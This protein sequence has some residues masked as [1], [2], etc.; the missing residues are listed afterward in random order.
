MLLMN[1]FKFNYKIP[2]TT[3]ISVYE[4]HT[5]I[6]YLTKIQMQIKRAIL[7]KLAQQ[8]SISCSQDCVSACVRACVR[9]CA[10]CCCFFWDRTSWTAGWPHTWSPNLLVS[11]PR[12]LSI[13]AWTTMPG[14]IDTYFYLLLLLLCM[15][16][17]SGPCIREV[18][19]QLCGTGSVL[20]PLCECRSL[21]LH[22][23]FTCSTISLALLHT[24]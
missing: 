17:L 10:C 2:V 3:V 18:R 9:V 7:R 14:P 5:N 12:V 24:L 16:L 11:T 21:G 20:P 19:G 8:H 4:R 1:D 15:R 6:P 22:S 23:I 13:W